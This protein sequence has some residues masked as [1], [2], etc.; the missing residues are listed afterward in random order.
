MKTFDYNGDG[1]WSVEP[2]LK[3]YDSYAQLYNVSPPYNVKPSII[4]EDGVTRIYPVMDRIIEGIASNDPACIEIGVEF[5]EE[6]RSFPF[7]KILKSN[8]ARALRRASASMTEDQKERVRKRIAEMLC[9]G[10]LPRE[11][12]QYARLAREI[13]LGRW[14]SKI[15]QEANLNNR[16]VN[17]YYKIIRNKTINYKTLKSMARNFT[18]SFVS[19]M[20]YVDNGYVI[21][22]LQQLAENANG[23]RISIYWIP[24][25]APQASLPQRV[26]KSIGYYKDRLPEH[27][28]NSG[29][30]VESIREFRTDIFLK[31]GKQVAV[32]AYLVDDRGKEHICNVLL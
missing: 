15:E 13:G 14:R 27:I 11:F 5:I 12:R 26:V 30:D 10:Y 19:F 23:E 6:S 7:G 9:T 24:D 32:E 1:F 2:V 21:D 8:T 22:D 28:K 20:N 18:H 4:T 25:S 17:H 3:R 29:A 31:S 16:W